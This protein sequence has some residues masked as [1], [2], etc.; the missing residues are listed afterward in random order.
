MRNPRIDL[1]HVVVM[2]DEE[3]RLGEH[4]G[5]MTLCRLA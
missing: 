2:H 3:E 1:R 4:E 5:I